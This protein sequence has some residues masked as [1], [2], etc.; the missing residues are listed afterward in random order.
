MVGTLTNPQIKTGLNSAGTDLA[1]E[2]KQQAAVFRQT[3]N[4]QC[5]NNCECQNE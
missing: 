3:G 5:K 1:T 2:V 4:G